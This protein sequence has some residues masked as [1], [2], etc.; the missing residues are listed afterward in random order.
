MLHENGRLKVIGNT[1]TKYE[2]LAESETKFFIRERPVEFVFVKDASGRI[3]EMLL[4][5][6]GQEIRLKKL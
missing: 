6:N 3:T 4:Y 5:S 2:L 1:S